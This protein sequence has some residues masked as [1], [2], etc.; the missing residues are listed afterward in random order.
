MADAVAAPAHY[1][2]RVPGVECID[3]T[4]HFNFNLGNVIKY[5]WRAGV[6]SGDAVQDLEKARAYLDF[7]IGRLAAEKKTERPFTAA[8]RYGRLWRRYGYNPD[9]YYN[10]TNITTWDELKEWL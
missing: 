1:T 3:V 5:V 4:Q 10:G 9:L 7:E 6:K 2:D 8:D